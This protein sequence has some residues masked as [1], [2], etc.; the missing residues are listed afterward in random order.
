MKKR[1]YLQKIKN[2]IV[3]RLKYHAP[4]LNSDE[5]DFELLSAVGIEASLPV[6][7]FPRPMTRLFFRA[8]REVKRS[9]EFNLVCTQ[10]PQVRESRLK[11]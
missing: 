1:E 11:N 2:L 7:I 5:I 10:K 4:N 8:F 3:N 6:F 9:V